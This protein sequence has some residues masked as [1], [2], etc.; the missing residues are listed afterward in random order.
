MGDS[1]RMLEPLAA[2]TLALLTDTVRGP[3]KHRDF[4]CQPGPV[5]HRST[6]PRAE[7]RERTKQ[8]KRIKRQNQRAAR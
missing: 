5:G 6:I 1:L 4:A 3:K 7:R 8:K 2:A